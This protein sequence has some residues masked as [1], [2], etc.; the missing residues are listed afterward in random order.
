M[1][2]SLSACAALQIAQS[3]DAWKPNCIEQGIGTTELVPFP[4]TGV[5]GCQ[6]P[7]AGLRGPAESGLR[8]LGEAFKGSGVI[9]GQIRKDLAVQFHAI[10]L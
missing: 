6:V 10:F 1:D 5:A 8:L 9:R 4:T 7:E 2:E 3:P